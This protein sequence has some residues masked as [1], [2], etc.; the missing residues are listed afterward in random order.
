MDDN[1]ELLILGET[2]TPLDAVLEIPCNAPAPLVVNG[3]QYTGCQR[4][5]GHDGPHQLSISWER[6]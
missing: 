4:V 6:M 1:D 5:Q 2:V 3:R